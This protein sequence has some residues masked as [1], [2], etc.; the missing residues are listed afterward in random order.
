MARAEQSAARRTISFR[1]LG[2]EEYLSIVREL[3][4]DL[5]LKLPAEELEDL[6]RR[7]SEKHGFTPRSARLLTGYLYACKE[8]GKEYKV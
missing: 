8:K 7:W 1:S 4:K 6:G 3:S 5:K 2:E